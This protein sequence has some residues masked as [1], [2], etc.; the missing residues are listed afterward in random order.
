MSGQRGPRNCESDGEN[1][2]SGNAR[3]EKRRDGNSDDIRDSVS[4]EHTEEVSEICKGVTLQVDSG[5][6]C[7]GRV[8][9]NTSAS[10]RW[11]RER[12]HVFEDKRLCNQRTL[13]YSKFEV[14][15][16]EYEVAILKPQF[17]ISL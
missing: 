12:K 11:L 2:V 15:R 9:V 14:M 16:D 4:C 13:I 7:T 1:E 8:L 10:G 3:C 5:A 17:F 6:G